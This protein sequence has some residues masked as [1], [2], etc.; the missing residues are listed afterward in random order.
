MKAQRY[1]LRVLIVHGHA[2]F[3]QA[4]AVVLGAQ[5]GFEA[6]AQAG[7]LAEARA[8]L[9]S[10]G[11][12]PIDVA[13]VDLGLPDRDGTELV[14]E[15]IDGEPAIPVLALAD[16]LDLRQRGTAAGAREVLT[17]GDSLGKI[18]DALGSLG[19]RGR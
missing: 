7:S 18:L 14:R 16:R 6:A 3:R 4:L 8:C 11:A 13:V 15:L 1:T 12:S 17:R 19:G 9:R 2:A 5:P 10:G